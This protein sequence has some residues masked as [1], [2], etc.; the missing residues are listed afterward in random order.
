LFKFLYKPWFY[1][2]LFYHFLVVTVVT[3]FVILQLQQLHGTESSN[4]WLTSSQ[5]LATS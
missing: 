3:Y 4:H 2:V 5:Q 1:T